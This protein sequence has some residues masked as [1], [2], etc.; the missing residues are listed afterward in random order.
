MNRKRSVQLGT[1][2]YEGEN[3]MVSTRF[4]MLGSLAEAESSGNLDQV[5]VSV[6]KMAKSWEDLR[7]FQG[8]ECHGT[9]IF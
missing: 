5:S 9:V 1:I 3:K 6:S 7:G 4:N 8:R 2:H